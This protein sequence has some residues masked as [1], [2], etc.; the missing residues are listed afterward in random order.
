MKGRVWPTLHVD[1]LCYTSI[2]NADTSGAFLRNSWHH[3]N[4]TARIPGFLQRGIVIARAEAAARDLAR[5]IGRPTDDVLGAG[6]GSASRLGE[7]ASSGHP[8]HPCS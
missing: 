7:L 5:L 4:D 1:R 6:E 3:E 8:P 2:V